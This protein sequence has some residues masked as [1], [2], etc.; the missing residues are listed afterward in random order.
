MPEVQHTY[1]DTGTFPVQ[2]IVQNSEG[3]ADTMISYIEI[4]PENTFW[5]PT[6]FNP[7]STT[8]ENTNFIPAGTGIDPE[9]FHMIV[10]NRWG[11][12]AFKTF[13]VNHGWNGKLKNGEFAKSGTYTWVVIYKDLSGKTKQKTGSV[14]LIE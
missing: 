9:N 2:L 4:S 11:G 8:G 3:C 1:Q 5:V 6:A 12:K 7:H 10:Y 13:D 14:T